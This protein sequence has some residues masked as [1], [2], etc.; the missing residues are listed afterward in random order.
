VRRQLVRRRLGELPCPADAR[1][2][3]VESDARAPHALPRRAAS[4]WGTV[5]EGGRDCDGQ[6]GTSHSES[7]FL[8][9]G[10]WISEW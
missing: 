7:S 3:G 6:R 8:A 1:A 2:E 5:G 4:G 9:L 10:L